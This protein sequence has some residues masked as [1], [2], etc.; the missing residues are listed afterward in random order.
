MML[1]MNFSN[2]SY[3]G[4]SPLDDTLYN[5]F[6]SIN[7]NS[8]ILTVL[9]VSLTVLGFRMKDCTLPNPF[10]FKAF[11]FCIAAVWLMGESF[12][13]DNTLQHIAS[14]HGQRVKSV[15]YLMGAMYFI[16]VLLRFFYLCVVGQLDISFE[17]SP[18]G[19]RICAWMKKHLFAVVA[20]LLLLCWAVPVITCYPAN[21]CNDTW[22]Q[23]SQYWGFSAF[24]S[25][26]PPAQTLIFGFF[27]WLGTLVGSANI[28]LYLFVLVQTLLYAFLIAYSFTLMRR[29][30]APKWLYILTFGAS[31]FS[32]YYA[33]R[34]TMLLKD[35][36]Y[37]LTVLLFTIELIYALLQLEDFL[38]KKRHLALTILSV[39]GIILFRNN[40]KYILY[41]TIFVLAILLIYKRKSLQKKLVMR[42]LGLLLC[43]VLLAGIVS[44]VINNVYDIESG[45]IAEAL[46]LPFQQ[47]ARCVSL[48]AGEITGEEASA[49]SAI[50]DYDVLLTQYTPYVSDPVKATFNRD[51]TAEELAE[52]FKVWFKMF[53][54]YPQTYIE[55][56][57][58]QNYYLIYPFHNN[59]AIYMRFNDFSEELMAPLKEQVGLEE[60][61]VFASQKNTLIHWNNLMH[62]LPSIS[63]LSHSAPYTII[64][65][66]LS[67]LAFCRK[68]YRF[69][70]PALPI[71]L[72][73]VVIILA[74]VIWGH[75]RYAFPIIYT[76]PLLIA[77]YRYLANETK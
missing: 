48:H 39:L 40:G 54:K 15:I 62:N 22:I 1:C 51:A 59:V 10:L 61:T 43:P 76:V 36:L 32:P 18:K 47:T 5:I 6:A 49:I 77:Y 17:T 25:H 27:T 46:S 13:I 69:L 75:P 73:V 14:T 55:A 7:G 23:L 21:L 38:T 4:L 68:E 60:V 63:L 52:Y 50:L 35:N 26:H 57:L 3:V 65:L 20:V 9:T 58:N 30:T 42:G 67:L 66:F 34:V 64:L 28:G 56:T 12:Q 11:S 53:F 45:S 70:L 37:S 44:A 74:P 29:L 19:E 16:E 2:N 71:L 72:S 8:V 31:A 41:P 33:N 24:T